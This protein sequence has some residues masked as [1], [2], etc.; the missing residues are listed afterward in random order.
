MVDH[1]CRHHAHDPLL[2]VVVVA[3]GVWVWRVL[4]ELG[5]L[6]SL[7]P[8]GAGRG[9][10]H[11]SADKLCGQSQETQEKKKKIASTTRG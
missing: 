9:R 3:R 11:L 2:G 10:C 8:D 1:L 4:D 6:A 5:L 7:V